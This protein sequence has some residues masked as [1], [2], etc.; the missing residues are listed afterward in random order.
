MLKSHFQ[1][2]GLASVLGGMR[3]AE[4]SSRD[5]VVAVHGVLGAALPSLKRVFQHYCLVAEQNG[6][7]DN[8]FTLS[9]K[10]WDAFTKDCKLKI[11]GAVN[12]VF[13]ETLPTA[14]CKVR[15]FIWELEGEPLCTGDGGSFKI[16]DDSNGPI[17]R[18]ISLGRKLHDSRQGSHGTHRGAGDLLFPPPCQRPEGALAGRSR[19]SRLRAGAVLPLPL[20]RNPSQQ[21]DVRAPVCVLARWSQ[22]SWSSR[23]S[24]RRWCVWRS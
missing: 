12:K 8:P 24:C 23:V 10:Q 14:K 6:P 15:G 18:L 1:V 21:T 3:C 2:P 9:Q 22:A 19:S 17:K 5:E 16:D 13:A 11:K 7:S 20:H 4:H